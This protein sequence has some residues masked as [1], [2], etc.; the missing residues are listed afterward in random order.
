MFVLLAGRRIAESDDT[1][2]GMAG[3]LRGGVGSPRLWRDQHRGAGAASL[4]PNFLPEDRFDSQPLVDEERL[5]VCV[6]R[7]DNRDE[8]LWRLGLDPQAGLSDSGL[9]AAAYARWRGDCATEVVGDFAFAAWE[10]AENLVIA[11]VDHLGHQRL[12]WSLVGDGIAL[13]PQ[14][15]A[16]LRHPRVSRDPDLGSM[17]RLFDLGVDRSSTPFLRVRAVPG[18]HLLA[19]Q[20]GRAPRVTRWWNPA[21]RPVVWH[22]DPADYV[23]ETRELL[24][25]AVAAQLRSSTPISCTLSGGLDSGCVTA[26]AARALENRGEGLTAY[27]AVPTRG[28]APSQRSGWEP[29]DRRYAHQ[30]AAGQ[31][32]VHHRLISPGGQSVLDLLPRIHDRAC[33]P[34]KSTTNLLWLD[35]ISSS[36]ASQGSRTILLGAHGNAGFSW[37]GTNHL[38]ELARHRHLRAAAAQTKLEAR[39]SRRS[40]TRVLAGAVRAALRARSRRSVGDRA[41]PPG[42]GLLRAEVRASLPPR[43]GVYAYP[44][45]SRAAWVAF[46]TS[47]QHVWWPGPEAQWGV[48]WR[49]PTADRRLLERLLQFPQAAF[50]IGGADRG[51]ARAATE[52]LLPETVRLRRTQGAQVP[53]A[54]SLISVHVSQY[55]AAL[56]DM[57]RTPAC[58]ELFD[59]AAVEASLRKLVAGAGDYYL[60]L[61]VDRAFDVGLFLAGLELGTWAH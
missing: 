28:L 16:L 19:W 25:R 17:A 29:D 35:G 40:S 14:L 60:A 8:L 57:R 43:G 45:G 49:D 5:F 21:S 12:Y 50:R 41:R 26:L 18:G 42:P 7:I 23:A 6:A 27:T 34:T 38:W 58:H 46:A 37:R 3:A 24:E 48:Q 47:P 56:G 51:L 44:A 52:G 55:E 36:A 54:P 1:L 22:R 10:R 4:T 32:N 33:T 11:G 53:E 31:G 13:S 15:P 9:L 30:V 59:L 61:V 20:G 2:E 39:A